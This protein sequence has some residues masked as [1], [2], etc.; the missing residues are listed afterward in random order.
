MGVD[1]AVADGLAPNFAMACERVVG[2]A[3][4]VA[5]IMANGDAVPLRELLEGLLGRDSFGRGEVSHEVNVLKAGKMVDKDGRRGVSLVGKSS[6]ELRDETDLG[7]LELIHGDALVGAVA[8]KTGVFV[9]AFVLHGIFV[10][11]PKRHPA[12]LG[13]V[14][15]RSLRG[16]SPFS[17]SNFSLSKDKCPSR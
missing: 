12:H 8:T 9:F 3:A 5:M 1:A 2:K 4:V 17:A 11:A 7:G 14:T 13:G 15:L 6:L 16:I 10:M